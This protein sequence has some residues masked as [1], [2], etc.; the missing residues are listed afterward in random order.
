MLVEYS[1][2]AL[3]WNRDRSP[4]AGAGLGV[5]KVR[6]RRPCAK[7]P[8]RVARRPEPA[9]DQNMAARILQAKAQSRVTRLGPYRSD[10][11]TRD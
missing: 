1:W 11:L 10:R 9:S 3:Q 5:P 8:V 4:L 7:G 2:D 6:G